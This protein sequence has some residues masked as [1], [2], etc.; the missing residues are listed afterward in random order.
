[1][2]QLSKALVVIAKGAGGE[3]ATPDGPESGRAFRRAGD[4]CISN[5]WVIGD[6]PMP[7]CFAG[8]SAG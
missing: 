4:S 1:M 3:N 7:E 6:S 5:G 8:R 2:R